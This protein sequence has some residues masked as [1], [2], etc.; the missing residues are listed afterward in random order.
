MAAITLIRAVWDTFFFPLS[1]Q[2]TVAI[3]TPASR[4]TSFIVGIYTSEI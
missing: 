4:A 3:L 2:E 1:A